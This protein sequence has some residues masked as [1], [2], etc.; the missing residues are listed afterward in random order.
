[1]HA[2]K[3]QG[4]N[5]NAGD[6]VCTLEDVLNDKEC[7]KI[8]VFNI[9][10]R[11]TLSQ[12]EASL[13]EIPNFEYSKCRRFTQSTYFHLQFDVWINQQPNSNIYKNII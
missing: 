3:K 4:L 11:K 9:S 7:L 8:C 2:K 5:K 13:K 6:S 10:K 1:M 12:I